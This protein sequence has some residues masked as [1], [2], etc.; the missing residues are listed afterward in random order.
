MTEVSHIEF[1][2]SAMQ[3]YARFLKQAPRI[4]HEEMAVSVE[5][6]LSLLESQL[7]DLHAY[8]P[9]ATGM[10]RGSVYHQMRGTAISQGLG[11]AG[12]V[13]SPLNYAVPV[14]LGTKPHWIGKKGIDSLEDWV[15]AKLGIGGKEARS[16]AFAIRNKIATKGTKG[17]HMF[18]RAFNDKEPQI[19]QIIAAAIPRIIARLE[20]GDR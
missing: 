20:A 19:Q 18:E 4:A 2:T 10:L 8:T 3:E 16:V 9:S 13:G 12:I 6:A 17:A 1:D 15:R 14:E 7:K 5:E 11:V